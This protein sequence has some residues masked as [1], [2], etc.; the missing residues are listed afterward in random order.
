M[1]FGRGASFY[2]FTAPLL[3]FTRDELLWVVSHS[4]VTHPVLGGIQTSSLLYLW[5][6]IFSIF[7]IIQNLPEFG[8]SQSIVLVLPLS[9]QWDHWLTSCCSWEVFPESWG[10]ITFGEHPGFQQALPPQEES[11]RVVEALYL[12]VFL[13][14]KNLTETQ[15]IGSLPRAER[16]AKEGRTA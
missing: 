3:D 16:S 11:R 9:G 1:T 4:Y 6:T 13:F 15:E 2:N 12:S 8:V 10:S 14:T 7:K 5:V